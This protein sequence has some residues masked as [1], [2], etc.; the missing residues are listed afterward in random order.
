[1]KRSVAVLAWLLASSAVTRVGAAPV[2]E[3]CPTVDPFAAIR[4]HRYPP[5]QKSLSKAEYD[6]QDSDA[7]QPGQEGV[8]HIV[9]LV[10]ASHRSQC[11]PVRLVIVHGAAD[12]DSRGT[13]FEDN[14]SIERAFTAMTELKEAVET[15]R[16]SAVE[17]GEITDISVGFTLGGLGTRA[18]VHKNPTSEA[19]RAENRYVTVRFAHGPIATPATGEES[20]PEPSGEE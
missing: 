3:S 8:D 2:E 5:E 4:F 19:E 7:D 6:V 15:A 18:A 10:L 13:A 16:K 14:V 9:R 11:A 20:A 1:M 12:F 17:K